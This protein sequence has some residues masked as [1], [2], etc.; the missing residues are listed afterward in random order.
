MNS[1]KLTDTGKGSGKT[2][3]K[4]CLAEREVLSHVNDLNQKLELALTQDV[5]KAT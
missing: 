5:L 4:L 3:R 1:D 2:K